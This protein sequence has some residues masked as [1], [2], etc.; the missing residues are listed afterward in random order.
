[1]TEINKTRKYDCNDCSGHR[2]SS[3]NIPQYYYRTQMPVVFRHIMGGFDGVG[4]TSNRWNWVVP[5]SAAEDT[6]TRGIAAFGD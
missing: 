2:Y 3:T 5:P 4:Q 6:A 1:M